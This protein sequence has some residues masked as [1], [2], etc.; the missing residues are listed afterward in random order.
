MF[1]FQSG[2]IQ[3]LVTVI[4]Y[5]PVISLIRDSVQAAGQAE[6]VPQLLIAFVIAL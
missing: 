6:Q 4:D 5:I 1:S 3:H 2:I